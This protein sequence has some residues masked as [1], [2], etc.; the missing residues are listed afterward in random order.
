MTGVFDY[1]PNLDN[2]GSRTKK[3]VRLTFALWEAR[4]VVE[5]EVYG[6]LRGEWLVSRAVELVYES[7][8]DTGGFTLHYP[9]GD[10]LLCTDDMDEKEQWIFEM[11]VGFE[12]LS[13]E[14]VTDQKP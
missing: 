1:D 11:L 12:V 10:E 2:C 7:T 9:D 6:N 13:I 3:Q 14:P 8:T 4:R 5:V